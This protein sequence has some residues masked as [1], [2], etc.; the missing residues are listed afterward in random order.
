MAELADSIEF[1]VV[2]DNDRRCLFV[3]SLDIRLLQTDAQA[4]QM[5]PT[6]FQQKSVRVVHAHFVPR[7]M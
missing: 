2:N 3:L 5:A 4:V 7:G 1:V 6:N